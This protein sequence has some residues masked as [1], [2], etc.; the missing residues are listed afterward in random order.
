LVGGSVGVRDRRH[1][2]V[3]TFAGGNVSV[4]GERDAV[5]GVVDG[6]EVVVRVDFLKVL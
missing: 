3:D 4:L 6:E 1:I 5:G 2:L